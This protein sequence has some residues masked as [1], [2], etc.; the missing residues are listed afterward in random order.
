MSMFSDQDH[1]EKHLESYIINKLQANGWV[2]GQSNH[3][4]ME[5]ALYPE[6]LF[7]WIKASQPQKWQKL[8]DLNGVNTE[9]VI[10]DRLDTELNAKGTMKVF[11]EGFKIAGAGTIDISESAPEDQ[12]NQT[13][14]DKYQANIL[15]VVPQL[16][17]HPSKD[18]GILDLVFFINGLPM[19]TV[20]IKTE[21]NQTIEDAI[22]QY[23]ND[24]Q[25]IDPKTKRKEPLFTKGRGAIVHFALTESLIFMTTE[26]CGE[27]TFF[28]PFNRGNHGHAG[29]QPA[30]TDKGEDYPIAYFWDYILKRD[31]WLSI[32]HHFVYIETKNKVDLFNNWKK[33]ER[34]IF[35]RYHQ[36]DAV[37]KI[38]ADIKQNG[39][40][41]NYLCEH[42]AGSGKTSTISWLCHSLIRLR[43]KNG[44]PF[45]NSVIVVT[46]RTVLDNQ[47]QE[48]IQQIDHQYGL[49][50]AINRDSKEQAGKSKS[51]Q[52]EE[53]LLSDK[54]IIIVTIQTFPHVM[55]AILTNTSLSDRN[56]GIVIDEA[57]TSQTGATASKLQATLALK[58]EKDMESLTIEELLEKIQ[59]SRVQ[60]KSISHFAFTAT[61]KHSTKMLFGRTKNGQPATDTNLPQ[62]FH[63][64]T[65][66][67]AIEEGFIL[68][69][70]KGYVSY[71]TAYRLGGDA[72][73]DDK[74]I[75]SKAAKKALAKWMSLH[76]TN[77]TQKVKF[78]IEHFHNNVA[79]LLNGQAKAMIVT[80]S[81]PA[82][83]RYKLAL[84]KYIQDNP[85]YSQYHVLVAF[86]GSLTGKQISHDDDGEVQG[87]E[88]FNIGEDAEFTEASMNLNIPNSDLRV[89][90]DRP[91]YRLMVVAN[92]F[93]TGFD[94]PKLCA[95]YLDKK[96]ANEVEVVQ[97]LSRLNRTT[98]GKDQ[99]Y[100]IDFVN[101]A[102][103]IEKCFKKYDSG[104]E[105]LNI[106][107]P[108]IVYTIKDHLDEVNL[109]TKDDLE[110]FKI[111]R[112]KTIKDINNNNFSAIKH[113][114]LFKSTDHIVRL[115]NERLKKLK[116]DIAFLRDEFD[117]AVKEGNKD[118]ADKAEFERKSLDVELQKLTDFKSNL[119]KFG[120][121]YTYVAQLIDFGDPALENFA[122]FSKLVA[123]RLNGLGVQEVDISGLVLT[124]YGIFKNTKE[125][126][127]ED[128]KDQS[129]PLVPIISNNNKEKQPSNLIYLKEIIDKIS[130]IFGDIS[131]SA[132]HI[133][134]INH[135]ISIVRKDSVVMA[136]IKNNSEETALKG[137]LQTSVKNAVFTAFISHQ[138]AA[139]LL[140][141]DKQ[142]MS[143]FTKL[144][145]SL[146]KDDKNLNLKDL[147]IL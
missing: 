29:N 51:K 58:S 73:D 117:N 125:D 70:L 127:T 104:A 116:E 107:D 65:Q 39:V 61:P 21:F 146:L 129:S 18:S 100:I 5:Y 44:T 28:L 106:Q 84:D 11:R 89:T 14:I 34:L 119:G 81:R 35:P 80:S 16:K 121:I 63:L 4:H 9:K 2:V 97:T 40:G 96:I 75:D 36:F 102:E 59:Q 77:V 98:T 49:I 27:S 10:L 71:Q 93:Q 109:Y 20:E 30:M 83:A 55:E 78:I 124:G 33:Q 41:L 120:R 64:Y 105:I 144:L 76:A 126:P 1:Y 91:E 112:F 136:Q 132:E 47:L 118:S 114:D 115:Y 46:D 6:D 38:I 140:L 142:A 138:Q 13:V 74:R 12:R 87:G 82:A 99:I 26:L 31:Y 101:D 42:S 15:R 110:K 23:K 72:I 45:Y 60:S 22:W 50:A 145:Y 88:I 69:V 57:H 133:I 108:N 79:N 135:L 92:K 141:K 43:E 128:E 111:A 25:P 68:D 122:A 19:A 139:S 54:P 123:K 62:S 3:Y 90:F 67:Q 52:L 56:Y 143:D 113:P 134:F 130:A 137:N 32:F 37:N 53:A 86:S 24:R 8:S 94:Q 66:R 17:Y 85:E 131:T 95:M 103:W 147:N 7:A 48:A